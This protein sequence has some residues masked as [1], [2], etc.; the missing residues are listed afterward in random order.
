MVYLDLMEGV[1][2]PP[3]MSIS[4]VY[5][6]LMEGVPPPSMSI[7]Q[8]TKRVAHFSESLGMQ[9][10]IVHHSA[11]EADT[12]QHER[13]ESISLVGSVKVLLFGEVGIFSSRQRQG[14][15]IRGKSLSL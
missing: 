8:G 5:L 15:F 4:M 6:D 1:P 2:P 9:F 3:S 14:T 13:K 10:A 7:M 11:S 12:P